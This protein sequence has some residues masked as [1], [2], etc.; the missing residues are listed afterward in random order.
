MAGCYLH[1]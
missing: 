1:F